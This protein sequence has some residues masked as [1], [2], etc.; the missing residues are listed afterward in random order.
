[1]APARL[2]LRP[3]ADIVEIGSNDGYLL[4]NFLNKDFNVVGIEPSKNV[5]SV[6][7]SKGIR[8]VE[9]FFGSRLAEF[10]GRSLFRLIC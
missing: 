1:M 6:A 3:D 2:N 9:K 10:S 7:R 5:A 4:Q 8:T